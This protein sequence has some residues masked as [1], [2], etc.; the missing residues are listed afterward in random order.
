MSFR[1]GESMLPVLAVQWVAIR[2][3]LSFQEDTAYWS[4]TLWAGSFLWDSQVS[5]FTMPF[6]L[7][8]SPQ[9]GERQQVLVT[10]ESFD[11]KFYVAHN[12]FYEQ[13]RDTSALSSQRFLQSE[14]V[15][16]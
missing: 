4:R 6:F 1:K 15:V 13:V 2:S 10:E 16:K 14:K 12:R 3:L 5:V 11:S 7:P 9:I 8:L